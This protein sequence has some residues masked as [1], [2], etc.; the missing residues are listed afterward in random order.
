QLPQPQVAVVGRGDHG[1]YFFEQKWTKSSNTFRLQLG[2]PVRFIRPVA[3]CDLAVGDVSRT[4]F[5]PSIKVNDFNNG[6][7]AG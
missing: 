1:G 5:L 3:T 2:S 7:T 6:L 4:I